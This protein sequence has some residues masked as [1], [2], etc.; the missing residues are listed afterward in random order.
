VNHRDRIHH[1]I[2]RAIA[3]SSSAGAIR[4]RRNAER[5]ARASPF[6]STACARLARD[7]Q[8]MR[9]PSVL[10]AADLDSAQ[11]DHISRGF[12]RRL[13]E[14]C[15]EVRE[16]PL[17]DEKMP[18]RS[19]RTRPNSCPPCFSSTSGS[20]ESRISSVRSS[21][22]SRPLTPNPA[23]RFLLVSDGLSTERTDVRPAATRLPPTNKAAATAEKCNSSANPGIQA[24]MHAETRAR[25]I[26]RRGTRQQCC[27]ISPPPA[28]PPNSPAS[29]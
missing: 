13:S 3:L 16:T 20:V 18:A 10:P 15:T 2:A 4:D 22:A 14:M 24:H 12:K 21:R 23:R 19:E 11:R 6:P 29:A 25:H 8:Q 28:C 17:S 7:S 5:P 27:L 1:R 9:T 26:E